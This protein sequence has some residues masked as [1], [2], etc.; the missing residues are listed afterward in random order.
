MIIKSALLASLLLI[1]V[2]QSA[3]WGQGKRYDIS[4]KVI[5]LENGQPLPGAE[6]FIHEL[7]TG[8][9][10]DVEGNFQFLNLKSARYHVHIK[11]IGYESIFKFINLDQDISG[12]V[13]RMQPSSLELREVVIESDPFKTGPVEKSLVVETVTS[14]FLQKNP[15]GT[16]MN[17]LQKL[18][19]INS[20]NMGVGI[21]KPVI[22]GLSFNRVIV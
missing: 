19:G 21:S 9:V 16:L 15:G 6:I 20:I 7:V 10:S 14:D 12:L 5:D 11:Y 8:T 3:A 2:F 13:F 17:S 1:L 22:R 4:G 18:P